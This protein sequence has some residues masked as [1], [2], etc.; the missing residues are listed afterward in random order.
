MRK[1]GIGALLLVS[2]ASASQAGTWYS[3]ATLKYVYSG[4]VGG[5][6]A[7]A[8]QSAIAIGNCP[9]AEFTIDSANPHLSRMYALLLAAYLA[10]LTVNVYTDGTCTPNGF[11]ATDVA[12]GNLL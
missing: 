7:F 1:F 2:Y 6:T 10:G 12:L 3:N 11:L 5:R 4:Q 9:S 8:I